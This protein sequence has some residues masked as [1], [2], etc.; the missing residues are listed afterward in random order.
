MTEVKVGADGKPVEQPKDQ[1]KEGTPKEPT[2]AEVQKAA[3]EE[4]KAAGEEKKEADTVPLASFLE[5]KSG[6]KEAEKRAEEANKALQDLKK[7][8]EAGATGAEISAEIKALGE[9]YQVDPVFL[10]KFAK[11]VKEEALKGAAKTAEDKLKPITE[12]ERQ[13]KVDAAFK[14]AFDTAMSGLG[15][16]YAKIVNPEVIKVLSLDPKNADK[17]F[18]EIIESAYSGALTGKRTAE[19]TKPGGGKEPAPLDFARA[20]KDTEYF[21]EVMADP[22]LKAEYNEQ[23]LKRGF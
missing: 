21:K 19:R 22:K 15:E 4:K 13:E 20:R 18:T 5:E 7:S 17:T 3:G 10:A 1:P 14:K 6:R 2:A 9:E 12:R 11:T 8:I 16:D 23:M